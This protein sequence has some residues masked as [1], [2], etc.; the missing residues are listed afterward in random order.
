MDNVPFDHQTL[1]LALENVG[2][3]FTPQRLAVFDHLSQ[4]V[5]HPTA[6]DV[7]QCVRAAIP[8]ISLATVHAPGTAGS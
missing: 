6:Q 3:R 8:R 2:L 4:T 7:Y 5:R 1:R